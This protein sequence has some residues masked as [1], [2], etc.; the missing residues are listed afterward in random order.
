MQKTADSLEDLEGR[1]E[2]WL[3]DIENKIAEVNSRSAATNDSGFTN[4]LDKLN[5]TE[6]NLL[7]E[8]TKLKE[9]L[10]DNTA[11]RERDSSMLMDRARNIFSE[12]IYCMIMWG[13][14]IK[15]PF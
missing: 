3:M 1:L 2:G 4:I 13:R 11:K 6:N 15:L 7:D 14:G 9:G 12:V 8:I 10:H 5:S